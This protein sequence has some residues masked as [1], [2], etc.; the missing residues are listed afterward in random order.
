MQ[1]SLGIHTVGAGLC[2]LTQLHE[3]IPGGEICLCSPLSLG[4]TAVGTSVSLPTQ[5]ELMG[6]LRLS[7]VLEVWEGPAVLA[8]TGRY[9]QSISFGE[10]LDAEE[11]NKLTLVLKH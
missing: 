11:R 4:L 1:P 5:H 8:E 9:D 3:H 10:E 7:Q 2:I 6:Y